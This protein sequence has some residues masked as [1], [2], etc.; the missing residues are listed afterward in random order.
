MSWRLEGTYFENCNCTVTCPCAVSGFAVPADNERCVVLLAFHIDSGEIDGVDVSGL[1]YAIIADAPGAMAEG[2]WRVG[3]LLDAA[4]TPEQAAALAPVASGQ[5][6]GAPAGFAPFIGEVLGMEAAAIEYVD[7]GPRHSVRIGDY[8]DV[9][10]EDYVPEGSTE[11]TRL[12]GVPHPVSS[13]LTAAHAT[14][15]KVR[16]FGIELDAVGKNGHA[17]PFSW[18]A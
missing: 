18:A 14:R 11:P 3:L 2:N 13:T 7:D 5:M 10:V 16:A 4:A 17:S 1:S 8:A 12:T 15:S 6:G 9:E